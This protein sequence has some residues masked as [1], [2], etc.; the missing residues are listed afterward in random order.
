MFTLF[1]KFGKALFILF[2]LLFVGIGCFVWWSNAELK[3]A[4]TAQVDGFVKSVSHEVVYNSKS[5]RN[6]N[7]Y[8]A[9]FAYS[10]EGVEYVDRSIFVTSTPKFSE[11]D[12]VTIFY[13]PADP[14]Q[15][16]V[17]EE[18]DGTMVKISLFIIT[19]GVA[20]V[21]IGFYSNIVPV[22]RIGGGRGH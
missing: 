7:E 22:F 19:F 14:Q 10:V 12:G 21:L 4:C 9:T 2:G 18:A 1:N 6:E 16:Y 5:K 17:L 15:F 8:R 20:F 3:R 13:N 11:G